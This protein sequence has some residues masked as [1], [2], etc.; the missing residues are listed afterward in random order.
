MSA[1]EEKE[2][3]KLLDLKCNKKILKDKLS[4]ESGKIV[5]LKDLSNLSTKA[6][7]TKTRNDLQSAVTK[8]SE[9]YGK[10]FL[11]LYSYVHCAG[12]LLEG[13]IMIT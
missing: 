5:L 4:Q 6:Q 7:S 8:L 2:A 10:L 3:I 9:T 11:V 12:F 13:S 1:D